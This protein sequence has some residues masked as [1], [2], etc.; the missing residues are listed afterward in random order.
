MIF[1]NFFFPK[2]CVGCRKVGTY[3]CEKCIHS[4]AQS[5]LVCPGCERLSIGGAVHPFC[6]RTYGLDG[7]WSLG[8][9][10][11]SLKK[12]IQK[13]KY[14]FVSDIADSLINLTI[15]YWVDFHPIFLKQLQNGEQWV[16]VSVPLH[17]KRQRWRGFNQAALLAYLFAQKLDLP[18]QDVLIR[19]RN[20]HQQV[21]LEASKRRSNIKN[22]F[23]LKPKSSIVNRNVLLIDDVWTTGSTLKECCYVLKRGG[24]KK[25]WAITLA[26]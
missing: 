25:V 21:G 24:A 4:I 14:R 16:I 23:L 5:E 6:T 2:F 20:T 8:I 17:Q 10:Q 11:G 22:A 3:F 26:R 9:Y 15:R 12:A 18:Y 19:K 7:L 1:F 13:L